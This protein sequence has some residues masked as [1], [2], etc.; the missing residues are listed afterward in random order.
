MSLN[1]EPTPRQEAKIEGVLT[2]K[3]VKVK[4]KGRTEELRMKGYGIE[5][6]D[7]LM[8]NF[9]E[10]L[11]LT[12]RGLLEV[13]NE[14]GETVGF[15]E[16]LRFSEKIDEN[17]WAKYMV[18]RDLRTRGYV[19]REGFGMGVDFRVYDRGD[20]GKDTAKYLVLTLQEGKPITLDKLTQIV[21]QCQSLKKELVVAVMSRR[22]EIVYYSV[23]QL[24]LP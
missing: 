1:I 4:A 13:K 24:T 10:A 8:L 11:H 16:I 15:Q 9:C 18:Y 2:D 20:Y 12:E 21:R 19:V 3:G 22:G 17:V 23:S 7:E 5:E 6:D 14:K